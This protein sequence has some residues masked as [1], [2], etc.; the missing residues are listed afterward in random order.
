MGARMIRQATYQHCTEF[1]EVANSVEFV[2][3]HAGQDRRF[4]IDALL[5]PRTGNFSTSAYIQEYVTLQPSYPY[6]NGQLTSAPTN[7]AVW[8]AFTHIGW[9]ARNSAE[10]AIEQALSFFGAP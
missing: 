7:F 5:D 10:S 6:V 8:V 1:Y 4:R 9:T 2:R 3:P